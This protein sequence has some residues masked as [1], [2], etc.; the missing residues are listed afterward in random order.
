[1]YEVREKGEGMEEEMIIALLLLL[2]LL[3]LI[4]V[5]SGT[6]SQVDETI[7]DMNW[8][9]EVRNDAADG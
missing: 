8:R 6:G 5:A 3:G 1:M 4:F 2:V 9:G 7:E